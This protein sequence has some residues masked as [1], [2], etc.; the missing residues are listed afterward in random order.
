MYQV[1]ENDRP[2][3]YPQQEAWKT[4]KFASFELAVEYA[5]LWLGL[6][7]SPANS[8]RWEVD[9]PFYYSLD[10]YITIIRL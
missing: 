3:E 7:N 8:Y 10:N 2:A 4:S 1:L 6:A 5:N 9:R